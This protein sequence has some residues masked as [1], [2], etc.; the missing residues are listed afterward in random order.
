MTLRIS[1]NFVFCSCLDFRLLS[2]LAFDI[3][4]N[5]SKADQAS[6]YLTLLPISFV[7]LF[8]SLRGAHVVEQPPETAS[9][10]AL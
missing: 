4:A 2:Y 7:D 6:H 1:Q 10:E 8:F 3:S 5:A 9:S